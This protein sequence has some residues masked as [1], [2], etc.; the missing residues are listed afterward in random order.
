MLRKILADAIAMEMIP[1]NPCN[2]VRPPADSRSDVIILDPAEV[3]DL[4]DAINPWFRSWIWFAAYSGLRWSEML[5]VRRRDLD[6]LRRTVSVR[7]QIIE[8]NGRFLGFGEPKTAAGKRTVDLPAFLCS[9]IE[10]QLAER[11]TARPGRAGLRE[12]PR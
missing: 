4:A 7:Q 8:V 12:H 5:G 6:V 2:S 10:E 3:R 9:V 11:A 1:R